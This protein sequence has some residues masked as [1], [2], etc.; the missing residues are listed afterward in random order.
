MHFFSG[1]STPNIDCV[2]VRILLF[3][4][5]VLPIP[6]PCYAQSLEKSIAFA[7]C[8]LVEADSIHQ[9]SARK[10]LF[11]DASLEFVLLP[12]FLENTSFARL[13][14]QC[15]KRF[16]PLTEGIL[17]IM[18]PISDSQSS[19]QDSLL[20]LGFEKIDFDIN[21]ALNNTSQNFALFK[22]EMKYE[23]FRLK[24]ILLKGK[25]VAF[26]DS[27]TLPSI[28]E[29]PK[30][31]TAQLSAYL[32]SLREWQG[33]PSIEIT[34]NRIWTAWF[35]G[36]GREPDAGNY[37]IVAISDNRGISWTDPYLII[38]HSN[39]DVRIMD[40]QLW[41][42]PLG[43]L[44]IMWVQ[45]TGAKG[46]DGLWG[47]WAI[48]TE[49]PQDPD[50]NWTS[51][52]RLCN[53]LTRNKPIVLYSG[54]WLLPSYDW[55][56]F[57]STVYISDDNG[58]RW[59]FQGGPVNEPVRNF[60]EHMCVQMNDSTIKM[61]Q[62]DIKESSSNDNGKT[63]T[64]LQHVSEFTAA[65]S[66]LYFGKLKSGNLILI[67]NDD[68]DKKRKNLSA[69]LSKDSGKTWGYPVMI[70]HRDDVSYPD[71]AQD[72]SGNIYIVYDR[73]RGKEKEI[74]MQIITEEHFKT[75]NEVVMASEKI[76]IISKGS[77]EKILDNK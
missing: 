66:R 68:K 61:M 55:I 3:V 6:F 73:S 23:R 53:G 41:K 30:V 48:Y 11:S 22:K 40:T 59:H 56:E 1:S 70:D 32:P 15:E 75:T 5:T 72:E 43:R 12:A 19:N 64:E 47:T 57:R 17:V 52:K 36:G 65:N 51:P 63:W 25:V 27:N 46:F 13:N 39:P 77:L 34:G 35:S 28:I 42:D 9:T 33:C 16:I 67:F 2:I 49:N 4:V 71:V 74:L 44:W 37:G 50:P 21:L 58:E 24:D 8:R 45:N 26:F 76:Q 69:Y 18:A 54:E 38:R 14:V 31:E 7:S 62:R 29:E 20:K 60:Y 10:K